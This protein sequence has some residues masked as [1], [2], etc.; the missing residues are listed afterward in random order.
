MYYI[1]LEPQQATKGGLILDHIKGDI[2]FKDVDF[3]YPTRPDQIVLNHFNLTIPAG[4]VVAVC[5]TSGGGK[6]TIA[7]VGHFIDGLFSP[8]FLFF[9]ALISSLL[10]SLIHS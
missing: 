4:K 2:Q 5:G 8:F 7:A 9:Q 3:E 10:S 6:S 1:Q